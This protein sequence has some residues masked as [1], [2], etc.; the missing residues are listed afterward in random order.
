MDLK[1]GDTHRLPDR[2][3]QPLHGLR[4]H[5]PVTAHLRGQAM[6]KYPNVQDG[7]LV[8]PKMK[9]YRMS[10]CDR[11]IERKPDGRFTVRAI[12]DDKGQVGFRASRDNRATG[13]MRRHRKAKP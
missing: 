7:E 4:S 2:Q 13:Q 9:G 8:I 11:V 3:V 1:L 10:C 6:K 12:P 5:P